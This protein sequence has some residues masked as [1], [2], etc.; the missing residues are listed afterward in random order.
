MSF[1]FFALVVIE[2]LRTVEVW[3]I[4]LGVN[5][6]WYAIRECMGRGIYA[7]VVDSGLQCVVGIKM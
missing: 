7:G 2:V 1:E 4:Y 3:V 5:K 6:E